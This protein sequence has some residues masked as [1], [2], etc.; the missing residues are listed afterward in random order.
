MSNSEKKKTH[1]Q[2]QP[3]EKDQ[4]ALKKGKSAEKPKSGKSAQNEGRTRGNSGHMEKS[5]SGAAKKTA[6]KKAGSAPKKREKKPESVLNAQ[7]ETRKEKT[8]PDQ[9]QRLELDKEFAADEAQEREDPAVVHEPAADEPEKP[10]EAR[11]ERTEKADPKTEQPEEEKT[12]K[13]TRRSDRNHRDEA[14]ERNGRRSRHIQVNRITQDEGNRRRVWTI[15]LLAVLGVV[16]LSCMS[17]GICIFKI[18]GRTFSESTTT[19]PFEMQSSLAEQLLQEDL[20]QQSEEEKSS[21][22]ELKEVEEVIRPTFTAVTDAEEGVYGNTDEIYNVLLCGLDGGSIENGRTD[23]MII[24][25]LNM[26]Q[27]KIK[28]VSMMRDTLVEVEG[29]DKNRL[30]TINVYVGTD[31]LVKA[32]EEYYGIPIDGYVKVSFSSTARII[33]ILGGV[34][35][36]VSSAEAAEI[37]S[38]GGDPVTPDAG[39]VLNGKQAVEY[40]RV[41]HTGSGEFG[42]TERQRKVIAALLKRCRSM[43]LSDAM[44]LVPEVVPN[45]RTGYDV[46]TVTEYAKRVFELRNAEFSTLRLPMDGYYE[47]GRYNGMY[48]L[49]VDFEANGRA[50]QNFIYGDGTLAGDQIKVL[51][52]ATD[53]E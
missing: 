25:S 44:A 37:E 28:L 5:G 40:M 8:E 35:M 50:V 43:S 49:N 41:R 45:I 12:L 19:M 3:A 33:N 22:A 34:P 17:V 32:V 1:A 26:T 13:R 46:A 15:A 52:E 4:E 27:K 42:R 6:K 53:A 18:I 11:N 7:E 30:N 31:A 10:S 23:S 14:E 38:R 51:N 24:V 29:H 36:W 39:N 2:K 21:I 9:E 20:A 48:V 47:A 16:L